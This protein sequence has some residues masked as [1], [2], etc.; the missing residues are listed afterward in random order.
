MY[1]RPRRLTLLARLAC[2]EDEEK[3]GVSGVFLVDQSSRR[4]ACLREEIRN[5]LLVLL[6]REDDEERR[7]FGGGARIGIGGGARIG[8]GSGARIGISGSA[9]ID[10]RIDGALSDAVVYEKGALS[11]FFN[12]YV[13]GLIKWY[14]G[15]R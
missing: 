2:M 9:R 10:T 6:A 7:T 1:H 15:G 3:D 5:C 12:R 14:T 13:V 8:I 11:P 4:V